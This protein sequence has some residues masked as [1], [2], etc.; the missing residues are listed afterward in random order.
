MGL[1]RVRT[2]IILSACAPL[3]FALTCVDR[4]RRVGQRSEWALWPAGERNLQRIGD[5]LREFALIRLV[6]QII[7]KHLDDRPSHGSQFAAFALVPHVL[8][9]EATVMVAIV[10]DTY[11]AGRIRH[12]NGV[13]NI[14]VRPGDDVMHVRRGKSEPQQC[15]PGACLLDGIGGS[16]Q[17]QRLLAARTS[18]DAPERRKPVSELIDGIP[19]PSGDRLAEHHQL[20]K[21]EILRVLDP[22][23]QRMHACQAVRQRAYCERLVLGSIQDVVHRGA[24]SVVPSGDVEIARRQR[25]ASWAFDGIELQRRMQ[26][27]ADG[28][29]GAHVRKQCLTVRRFRGGLGGEVL[30][31]VVLDFPGLRRLTIVVCGTHAG[32]DNR[33]ASG[34]GMKTGNVDNSTCMVRFC[35]AND[36]HAYEEPRCSCRS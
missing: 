20:V 1:L 11:F 23:I 15:E 24:V 25:A 36:E 5:M 18:H 12:I 14:A 17:F 2:G 7:R 35:D 19:E 27:E 10:F 29:V 34:I 8:A 21:V 28:S 9:A 22:R 3:V 31:H 13:S 26:R 30:T 33:F 6:P 32:H 16:E 4:N